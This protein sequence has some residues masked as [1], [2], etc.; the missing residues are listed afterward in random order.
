MDLLNRSPKA[1]LLISQRIT[2]LEGVLSEGE[3]L[4]RALPDKTISVDEGKEV[5]LEAVTPGHFDVRYNRA[6]L[7]AG[8][9]SYQSVVSKYPL[10]CEGSY[11]LSARSKYGNLM[12]GVCTEEVRRV[13]DKADLH[14]HEG[15]LVFNCSNGC[16]YREGMFESGDAGSTK[17]Q[18]ELDL[19]L[20]LRPQ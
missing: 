5:I 17:G 13:K 20:Q 6:R 3:L 12:A 10:A 7:E 19:L 11:R 18:K 16:V 9:R 1:R 2:D 4:K 15:S 8:S 14:Y